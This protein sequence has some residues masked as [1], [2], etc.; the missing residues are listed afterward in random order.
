MEY[1]KEVHRKSQSFFATPAYFKNVRLQLNILQEA[2][3]DE[4]SIARRK[5]AQKAHEDLFVEK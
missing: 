3:L 2:G 1:I 5:A 4:E